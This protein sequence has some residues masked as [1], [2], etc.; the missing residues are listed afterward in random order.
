MKIIIASL[1]GI[2]ILEKESDFLTFTELWAVLSNASVFT[3]AI[4]VSFS[5]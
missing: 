5:L 3:V 4:K 1:K 2:D